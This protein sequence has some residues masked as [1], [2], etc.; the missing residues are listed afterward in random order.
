MADLRRG[1]AV[2]PP[3]PMPAT[4]R[5]ERPVALPAVERHVTQGELELHRT[6]NDCWVAVHGRVYDVTAF[7][8]YHPGGKSSILKVAG[9]DATTLFDRVGHTVKMLERFKVS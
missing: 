6:K 7:L 8:P 4:S 5:V 2:K 1:T 9:S 3:Q